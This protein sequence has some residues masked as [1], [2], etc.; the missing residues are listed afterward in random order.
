MTALVVR[1]DARMLPVA[2]ASV[3]L[4]CTSPPYFALRSYTDGGDHYSGQVGSEPTP[5]EYVEALLAVTAECVRVLKPGGSIFVNLGDKYSQRV[6][7]R[8]SSHQDGLYPDRPDLRKDWKRD[9]AA[10]LT[11]SPAD[12][13]IR[14]GDGSTQ[15][16]REKSLMGLPWR[17]AIGCI[18]HLGLIL[19]AEIIWSKP[20]GLPESVTDRVRRSHETW[21]HFTVEPRYYAA[22][23]E[24]RAPS[25]PAN[26]RP[27]DARGPGPR[28]TVK[29]ANGHATVGREG[30][31]VEHHPLGKLPG[32]VQRVVIE[33]LKVPDW[34]GVDHFAAFPSWWPW[35][36]IKG[37]SP[38]AI[39]VVCS[40]GR[41][42]VSEKQAHGVAL[43]RNLRHI[44]G[45]DHPNGEGQRDVRYE[46]VG[47]ACACTPRTSHRGEGDW[48]AGRVVMPEHGSDDYHAPGN[49]VPRRP[50]G[51]GTKVP[52]SAGEWEYH[53]DDW[54]PPPTRR[55]VVLDPFGG[56]G[57]TAL[58]ADALDR[59]AITVDLSADYC[60][61]AA[62][63]I[64]ESGQGSRL[65]AKHEG[66]Q[67]PPQRRRPRAQGVLFDG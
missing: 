7:T 28:D 24:I 67:T 8:R 52:R 29:R 1:G 37:W 20:N 59:H 13:L 51:F 10:G 54:D 5:A 3:D 15:P 22:I 6:A 65:L 36:I 21:F 19:R 16:V 39:C 48:K 9:R 27:A 35:W 30:I 46:I 31:P 41:R 17:Y 50:G 45:Y 26:L 38:A 11:R 44:P 58:M 55:A 66:R 14:G 32:S 42:P 4:I 25:D 56:T 23:D 40:E 64:H 12:N 43:K 47:Y 2:D 33:P 53:F 62:W 63:R 60:R 18:D 61:L 49:A 34:L 57:T